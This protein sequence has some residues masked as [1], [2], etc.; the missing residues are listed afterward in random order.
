MQIHDTDGTKNIQLFIFWQQQQ[1]CL[2]SYVSIC[3]G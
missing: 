1:K 3:F 2:T